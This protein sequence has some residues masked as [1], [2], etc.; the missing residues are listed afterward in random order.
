MGQLK[1]TCSWKQWYSLCFQA[2]LHL[3][4]DSPLSVESVRLSLHASPFAAFPLY[5]FIKP[6]HC[7]NSKP[8]SKLS[9]LDRSFYQ[10]R[11]TSPASADCVY[12]YMYIV[13]I[14]VWIVCANGLSFFFAERVVPYRSCSLLLLLF[15]LFCSLIH[16]CLCFFP[17]LLQA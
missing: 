11:W 10:P 6:P 17:D 9:G 12:V 8:S 1:K 2:S 4:F 5:L 13:F 15:K 14:C 7:L 16:S 3:A